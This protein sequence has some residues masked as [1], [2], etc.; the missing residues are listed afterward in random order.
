MKL[1]VLGLFGARTRSFRNAAAGTRSILFVCRGN[2]IRS[3]MA[4]AL[5]RKH[6]RNAGFNAISVSSAGLQANPVCRADDRAVI[7]ASEFGVCLDEHR[8]RPLTPE[9]VATADAIFV[10][11]YG[12]GAELLSRYPPARRKVHMLGAFAGGRTSNS[13][14]IVDPF[15]GEMADVRRCCEKLE[16]CT[17]NLASMLVTRQQA[18]DTPSESASPA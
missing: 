15:S 11:D 17:R 6:L 7:L 5:L 2:I 1:R 16:V 13:T 12:N 4:A 3:P 10:M 8:A 14:E 9:Q 18:H